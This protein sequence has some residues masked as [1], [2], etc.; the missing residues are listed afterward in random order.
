VEGLNGLQFVAALR[1][2]EKYR[3]LVEK[4]A[5]SYNRGG[6]NE[7]LLPVNVVT[8]MRMEGAPNTKERIMAMEKGQWKEVFEFYNLHWCEKDGV[9]DMREEWCW[10]LGVPGLMERRE[11]MRE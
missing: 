4:N 1:E 2:N 3:N 8:G 7:L 9:E 11:E 6:E 10:F 5:R